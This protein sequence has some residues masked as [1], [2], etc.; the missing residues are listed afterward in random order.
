MFFYTLKVLFS[1]LLPCRFLI[2]NLWSFFVSY[3]IKY[4]SFLWLILRLLLKSMYTWIFSNLIMMCLCVY[5]AWSS[6]SI[7]DL[8]VYIFC[9]RE[10]IFMMSLFL[11]VFQSLWNLCCVCWIFLYSLKSVELFLEEVR[12][13]ANHFNILEFYS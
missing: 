2:R 12:G 13:F 5:T 9:K 6:L 7:W 11:I 10:K 3:Y 1:C 8:W 4:L